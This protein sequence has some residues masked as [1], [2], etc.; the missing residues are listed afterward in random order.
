MHF[1]MKI[2]WLTLLFAD[3]QATYDEDYQRTTEA[4]LIWYG[5]LE[6]LPSSIFDSNSK[7]FSIEDPELNR[8]IQE[9]RMSLKFLM[10]QY[11]PPVLDDTKA[12][13]ALK[14]VR[15]AL[16]RVIQFI[17]VHIPI[18][19][20]PLVDLWQG[21][22]NFIQLEG[23]VN[24]QRSKFILNVRTIPKQLVHM[25]PKLLYIIQDVNRLYDEYQES[26]KILKDSDVFD[27]EATKDIQR[28]L[29]RFSFTA[30]QCKIR[31]GNDVIQALQA[32]SP[33]LFSY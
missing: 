23:I 26:L 11:K 19:D 30:Y 12:Y 33:K 16:S 15:K 9:L 14:R 25:T 29:Q 7:E 21:R 18:Q 4:C 13:H 3:V 28:Q 10:T 22:E 6:L 2:Y 20:N 5:R 24:Q 8:S 17:Q 32:V 31:E 1:S 27:V